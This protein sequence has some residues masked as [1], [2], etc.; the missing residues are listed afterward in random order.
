LVREARQRAKK[1]RF[2]QSFDLIA[3]LRDVDLTKPENRLNLVI[4]LPHPPPNKPSRVAAMVSGALEVQ[5]KNL[6]LDVFTRDQILA[7]E[8][9]KR[10]IRKIAKRYDF[11]V[12]T[13]DLMPIIGRVMGPILGPRGKM[14][15]VVPPNADL[16]PIVERL[17]RSVRVR[18]RNEPVV[19][20]R[21]GSELNSDEEVA[22]NID[23]VLSE[24]A[25]KFPLRLHLDRLYVKLTMGPPVKLLAR[26]VFA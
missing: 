8:G 14:P 11:F 24:V 1:R 18:F 5:A 6:G 21:V 19:K 17:R 12:A 7:L 4:P 2:V 10:E 23:A 26:E 3:V 16:A 20:V 25:R 13:P 15:E 22:E 9:K